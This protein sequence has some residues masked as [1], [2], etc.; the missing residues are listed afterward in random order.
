LPVGGDGAREPGD[1]PTAIPRP[2]APDVSLLPAEIGVAAAVGLAAASYGTSLLTAAFGL[3]G[4]LALLAVL[5]T[6]LPPA[7]VIPVHG[8]VQ[9]GSNVGRAAVLWRH[10]ARGVV[11]PFLAGAAVGAALGGAVSV[12]LPPGAVEVAVALFI[13]WSVAFRPPRALR[14][15]GWAT[16]LVSSVLTMFFGATGPFVMAWLRSAELERRALVA[17]HA[18]LM[19]AQHAL[20]TAIFAALGFAYA[21]WLPLIA[22]LIVAGFLGTLTG[23]AVL[24]RIDEARF[25][26]VL[27]ALL[28]LL[29]L[30]L[31][32]TGVT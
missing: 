11:P 13:L 15:H 6:V 8:V 26:G 5:A 9:L 25:A 28:V 16:G 27:N 3:G 4:G 24:L 30:R 31:I 19:T 17:T 1:A 7:A 21:P 2:Q 10:V 12:E 18:T 32:W 14:R 20:K 29:A 23:R 22:L